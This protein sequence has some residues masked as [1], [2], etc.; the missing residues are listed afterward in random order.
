MRISFKKLGLFL[1]N[2]GMSI[3]KLKADKVVGNATLD[4]I[5]KDSGDV[6]TKS[7]ASICEYLGCQP[8][9]IMECVSDN[10]EGNE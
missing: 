1:S 10:E 7:I 2:R 4:K 9:D 6:S 8:G 3:Y 5:R